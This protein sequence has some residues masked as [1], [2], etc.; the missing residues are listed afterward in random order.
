MFH[1][2]GTVSDLLSM[3]HEGIQGSKGIAPLIHRHGTGYLYHRSFYLMVLLHQL[4][5]RVRRAFSRSRGEKDK[6]IPVQA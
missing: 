5:Q 1:V 3:R 4:I 6:A 2:T